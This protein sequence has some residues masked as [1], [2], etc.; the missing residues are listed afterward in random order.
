MTS[1]SPTKRTIKLKE[2]LLSSSY[3]L[4]IERAEFFTEIYKNN[5]NLPEIIK[6]AKAIAHTLKSM[7]IFIRDDEM[8]VGH[9][10]SKNLG[11][12]L[13]FELYSYKSFTDKEI[14]KQL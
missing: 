13:A 5:E 8:L 1:E 4:C 10:T 3:E 14:L 12:K 11:E 7:T 9:E 2:N 6:K